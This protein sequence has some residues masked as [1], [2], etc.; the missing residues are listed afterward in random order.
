MTGLF[1]NL[2]PQIVR[3]L[4]EETVRL[5]QAVPLSLE[6][7]TLV[8]AMQDPHNLEAIDDI[9]LQT[10]CDVQAVLASAEDVLTAIDKVFSVEKKQNKPSLTCV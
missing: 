4:P 7:N 8:V 5:Y 1:D 3:L 9:S 2:N 10:G 6:G